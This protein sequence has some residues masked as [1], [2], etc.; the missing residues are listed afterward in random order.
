MA[1]L[2]KEK[3]GA[4]KGPS[5]PPI[6]KDNQ[7]KPSSGSTKQSSKGTKKTSGDAVLK[8]Q[9]LALG[10]DQEDY[11]LLKG[12]GDMPAAGSSNHDVGYMATS[13][14]WRGT[15]VYFVQPAITKD[16]SKFLEDLK[17][18]SRNS[19]DKNKKGKDTSSKAPKGKPQEELP[20]PAKSSKKSKKPQPQTE[21]PSSQPT[22]SK[23]LPDTSKTKKTKKNKAQP[24][25]DPAEPPKP[26]P[27]PDVPKVQLP[28]KVTF[29]PKSP[30]VVHPTSQWYTSLPPLGSLRTPVDP[31]SASQITSLA[32]RATELHET[33]TRTFQ[34]S[35][36]SNS[37]ASEANFLSKIIS[38][39]T[40]SD[41]L[42]ALTLLVQS[43]PVHNT[44]A[45]DTLKGMAERGKGKG[46]R[47]ESLKAL[48]C[49]VDWWVG[50]GAPGR[51]L[52]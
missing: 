18:G 28:T 38:S 16:V 27:I 5:R 46:G 47:E 32:A 43:S 15:D 42:S 49:V 35:S 45:L 26:E 10:G 41:R 2:R 1:R 36:S 44:R 25:P 22:N 19:R 13:L 3:G 48:R 23:V 30:F 6:I 37:S 20:S 50:G 40:L 14:W 11:D 21:A 34:T 24:H 29:N 31:A 39:G 52:K 7:V 51:K 8:D 4:S 17:L 9:V 12:V 33:D